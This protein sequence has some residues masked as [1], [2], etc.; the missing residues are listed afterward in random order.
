MPPSHPRPEDL[1]TLVDVLATTA[2]HCASDGEDLLDHMVSVGD[3]A[4][5]ACLEA[6]IDDA[7]DVLR[8]IT[9]TCRELAFAVGAGSSPTL[10]QSPARSSVREAR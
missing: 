9:A 2:D 3:H 7:V 4:T 8:E 10:A 1:T 6:L 5:Q